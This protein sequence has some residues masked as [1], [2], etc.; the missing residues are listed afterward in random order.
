MKYS[1]V[2]NV[3]TTLI[4]ATGSSAFS[5]S[6]QQCPP[7][8][9]YTFD[10][11]N[12]LGRDSQDSKSIPQLTNEQAQLIL[13]E[14]AGASPLYSATS[15]KDEFPQEFLAKY[16]SSLHNKYFS[17]QQGYTGG[18]SAF[19]VSSGNNAGEKPATAIVVVNGLPD[20]S[21]LFEDSDT[22]NKKSRPFAIPD[23]KFVESPSPSFFRAFFDRL[24]N[25]VKTVMDSSNFQQTADKAATVVSDFVHDLEAA[26]IAGLKQTGALHK[27]HAMMGDKM[28]HMPCHKD[29]NK[30]DTSNAKTEL[31]G[32]AAKRFQ[33]DIARLRALGDKDTL[34]DGQT[35]FI[36]VE[37]LDLVLQNVNHNMDHYR[38]AVDQIAEVL[39][40]VSAN[41]A[42]NVR[43]MVI[44]APAD[45][46]TNKQVNMLRHHNPQPSANKLSKRDGASAAAH[47]PLKKRITGPFA[48][49]A[50]CEKA[51]KNCSG[52]GSCV[53]VGFNF[54]GTANVPVYG[55]ACKAVTVTN[56]HGKNSTIHYGGDLCQKKDVSVETSM[57]LWTGVTLVL[58][59]VA[60][61][62]LL[63]SIDKEPLPGILNIGKRASS[64]DS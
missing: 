30:D 25:D 12:V 24:A 5:N 57:F 26:A 31:V 15:V 34:K 47:K 51:T 8:A 58:A 45:A 6:N 29:T 28:G 50:A 36:R 39:R 64:S 54:N 1:V 35:A 41:L 55:C 56:K 22:N 37:S 21:A 40:D 27:R 17:H 48:S 7:A 62:K 53:R 3:A 20:A 43:L 63:Y 4:A 18:Q 23:F 49:V 46:C 44:A 19:D 52:R 13:A 32:V 61:V 9:V 16:M 59:L 60:G 33:D 38:A 14:F 42:D 11:E 2:L 10:S